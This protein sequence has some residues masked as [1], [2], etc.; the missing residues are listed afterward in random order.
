MS[1][2]QKEANEGTRGTFAAMNLVTGATGMLGTHVMLEL[3]IRGQKTKALIRKGANTSIV[4]KVFEFYY[5]EKNYFDQ[6]VWAEGDILDIISLQDAMKDCEVVYHT[7]A[8]VSYHKA[9]RKAMYTTNIEGTANVVNVALE[10]GIKKLCHVSSIAA[11]GKALQGVSLTEETE[12]KNSNENPHYGI[13]KHLAEMEVWRGIQEGLPSVIVNPGLIIGPGD[14][15]RSSGGIFT[16]LNEGLNYYPLGGTGVVSA[17]DCAIMM[18]DLVQKDISGERYL[19]VSENTDMKA[20]FEKVAESLG[21]PKPQKPATTFIMQVVRI[22][23][24]LKEKFTGRKAIVTR[25][26]VKRTTQQVFYN[27]EKVRSAIN[28]DFEPVGIAIEQTGRFFRTMK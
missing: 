24:W 25:E 19:L 14:F 4:K 10:T 12:W 16:K 23:E 15:S 8:I 18:A 7:A 20:V 6:I 11:L 28:R 17:K 26:S 1:F 13:T 9:D 22:A 5:P 3:L 21:K 27:N 2:Y